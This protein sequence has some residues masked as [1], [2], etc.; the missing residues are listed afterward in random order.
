MH[1]H[2]R[3]IG[4][5]FFQGQNYQVSPARSLCAA[6]HELKARRDRHGEMHLLTKRT[7]LH[8]ELY[9]MAGRHVCHG[10]PPQGLC[11]GYLL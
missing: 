7:G 4:R 1:N 6:F 2:H 8:L 11:K 10:I 5:H 9:S 3:Y